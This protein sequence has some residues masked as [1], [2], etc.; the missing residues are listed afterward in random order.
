MVEHCLPCLSSVSSLQQIQ[1]CPRLPSQ[2]W[3]P[4]MQLKQTSFA[5][6][7]IA[8]AMGADS[9]PS[10]AELGTRPVKEGL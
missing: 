10:G 4:L 5:R 8:G 9:G 3:R 7:V 6:T 2:M 1:A